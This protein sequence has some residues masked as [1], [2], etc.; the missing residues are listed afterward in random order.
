M[1]SAQEN[2]PYSRYGLGDVV[3]SQNVVTR[4]M[5]GASA[6]F[7]DAVTVNFVNPASYA[8]LKYTTFDVGIDYTGRTLKA[9]DPVRSLNSGYLIPSYIQV[10]LPLM[11]A[12]N[13]GMN[14]GIRPLTRI[15]YSLQQIGRLPGIDSVA[16]TYNGDGGSY[17]A[18]VGTGIGSKNFTVGINAGYTFGSKNYVSERILLNDSVL[19][20]KGKWADSTHFGGIFLHA[21]AQYAT[22]VSKSV[23]LKLGA[24]AQFKN[25]LNATRN[26]IRETFVNSATAGEV[27]KDSVYASTGNKGKIVSPGT[28]G[29]GIG[30]E[31]DLAWAINAEYSLTQWSDYRYYDEKDQ[32]KDIW[33]LRLGGSFIPN[34]KST[35][36]WGQVQYRAGFYIGSDYVTVNNNLPMYAFTFGAGFP[37]RKY[38]YSVYSGQYTT[39]NTAFEIGARGNKSNSLRESFYRISIGLSLSDIWFRKMQYN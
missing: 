15:N 23:T 17:Q 20:E 22:R 25:N 5:G 31:K 36:Y 33:L 35:G 26:I 14:F 18:Y 28:Y 19:Y 2:S 10:G 30:L 7:Y 16:T 39:I 29:F 24:F 38:G 37:V 1:V 8:R 4:A 13:W 21:G 27:I 6:A 3:P 9:T 12:K 32:V 11:R 34:Y